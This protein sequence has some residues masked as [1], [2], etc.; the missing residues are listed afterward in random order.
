M[1][2]PFEPEEVV[3]R[4]AAD[5]DGRKR[6]TAIMRLT[7]E[8]YKALSARASAAGPGRPVQVSVEQWSPPE[9]IALSETT[10]EMTVTGTS[11]PANEFF[12]APFNSG[13]VTLINDTDYV[14]VELQSS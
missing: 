12:Q 2:I 1:Q 14:I 4:V 5:K 13:T 6:L 11:Y 7:P 3:W 9:L 10:G 8:D